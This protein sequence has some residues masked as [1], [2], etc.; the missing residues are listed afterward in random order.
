MFAGDIR[1]ERVSR[2]RGFPALAL[3]PGRDVRE[4]ERRDRRHRRHVSV[5]IR[6]LP[7]RLEPHANPRCS[8][9]RRRRPRACR[10]AARPA[11]GHRSPPDGIA[12]S[13]SVQRMKE[14]G[15]LTFLSRGE[16]VRAAIAVVSGRR[17]TPRRRRAWRCST[18]AGT[19][20]TAA[21]SDF[22]RAGVTGHSSHRRSRSRLL[23]LGEG[24]PDTR[25][26][27]RLDC[28][29]EVSEFSVGVDGT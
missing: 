11:H 9:R 22:G 20:L 25:C 26:D 12:A 23:Q 27:R 7:A 1:R 19:R 21:G 8:S 29:R 14:F 16:R 28:V 15:H 13:R 24:A 10:L 6:E 17:R 5:M 18:P 3:A 4:V 2:M